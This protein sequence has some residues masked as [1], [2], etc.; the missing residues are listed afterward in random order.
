MQREVW[1]GRPQ[2]E[3]PLIVLRSMAWRVQADW[4]DS[5]LRVLS[6]TSLTMT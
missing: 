4:S 1:V 6:K 3:K 2:I 5:A